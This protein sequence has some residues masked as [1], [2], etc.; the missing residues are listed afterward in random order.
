MR[1]G[2]IGGG[3]CS[4][5]RRF[6]V[7]GVCCMERQMG[8]GRDSSWKEGS[9]RWV[10]FREVQCIRPSGIEGKEFRECYF[11]CVQGTCLG[12]GQVSK[13]ETRPGGQVFFFFAWVEVMREDGR[14]WKV[15]CIVGTRAESFQ[16]LV[17]CIGHGLWFLSSLLFCPIDALALKLWAF[18]SAMERE[19]G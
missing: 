4:R 10:G 13:S 19:E 14:K 7:F 9:V 12:L 18:E 15:V 2:G 17:V 8:W 3:F 5:W 16:F 6:V 11:V 1:R